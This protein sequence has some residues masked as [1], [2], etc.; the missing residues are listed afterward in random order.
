MNNQIA[1]DLNLSPKTVSTYKQ[2]ILQKLKI[3]SEW[4]L[5]VYVSKLEDIKTK[6][7]KSKW[8]SF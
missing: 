7:D 1:Y 3:D 8:L 2:R 6:K 5:A 4:D